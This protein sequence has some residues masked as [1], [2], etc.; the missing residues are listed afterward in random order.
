MEK[1][2]GTQ[3]LRRGTPSVSQKYSL[4]SNEIYLAFLRLQQGFCFVRDLQIGARGQLRVRVFRAGLEGENIRSTRARYGK[5]LLAIVL[6]L[7][8]EGLY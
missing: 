2:K 5:L 6:V 4:I 3:Q 1:E 8:P 7:Q